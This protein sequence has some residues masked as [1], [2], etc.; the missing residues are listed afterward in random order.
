[1]ANVLHNDRGINTS[2]E[3]VTLGTGKLKPD[4]YKLAHMTGTSGF[5]LTPEQRKEL[6]EYA[7]GGGTL[8]IDAAGGA[9]EF[10]ESMESELREVFGD[11]AK[12]VEAPLPVNHKVYSIGG[13]DLSRAAYRSYA[14]TRLSGINAPRLR[15]I[16][17]NNRTAVL[18]SQEDLSVGLV[19]MTID[20]IFGYEPQYASELMENITMLAMG[21]A[22]PRAVVPKPP[23]PPA[24]AKP[25]EEKKMEEKK[26]GDE[27]K[28]PGA[29]EKKKV[30]EKK[31]K[32]AK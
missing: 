10:K 19:G 31:K 28:K 17:I 4:V 7:D 3:T 27:P 14:R 21:G 24:E 22:V 1:M 9:A 8:L 32:D 2:V 16:E 23:E 26:K 6:K 5:K 20:G 12:S 18:Y 11:A 25:K 30:E 29:P 13:D 15:G